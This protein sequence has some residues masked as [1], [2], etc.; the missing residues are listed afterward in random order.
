MEAIVFAGTTEGRAVIASLLSRKIRT[1]ACIA[2]D[3]GKEILEDTIRNNEYLKLNTGRLDM[4]QI[5]TLIG[6][7]NAQ[8]LVIDATHPYAKDVT[9]NIKQAC[10]ETGTEYIR[11]LR[12]STLSADADGKLVFETLEDVISWA[13]KDT[14]LSK[15]LLLTTGSKDLR[16]Y[17]SIK[18]YKE[19]VYPRI[20]PDI[21]SLK[22]ASELGYKKANIICMQG[23]FS[24]KMNQALIE[25]TGV[26]AL[27]TKDT[28]KTGGFDEKLEAAGLMGI[29]TLVIKRPSDEAVGAYELPVMSAAEFEALIEKLEL[30]EN[31]L[32]EADLSQAV[33][34]KTAAS[35]ATIKGKDAETK[36]ADEQ[37]TLF[38]ES[39]GMY[40]RF[41]LF[42][43]LRD[44]K[45]TVIGAGKIAQRRIATLLRYGAEIKV[46]APEQTEKIREL[47]DEGKLI[48]KERNYQG[49]DLRG[50][51]LAVS[52]SDSRGVNHRVYEEAKELSIPVSIADEKDECSFYF[53]AV[54]QKG[55]I[56]IGLVSD[57]SDHS[58]TARTAKELRTYLDIK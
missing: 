51:V 15:K 47:A 36:T 41:P 54:M 10:R 46:I 29:V 34:E 12:K 16:A 24:T 13:N 4:Q 31:D 56:S 25:A 3:Y 17:T 22:N 58:K 32:K 35:T 6:S 39:S 1:T 21:D 33:S 49:G 43:D 37:S 26:E 28:G 48:L 23:P 20:L 53:P 30:D 8:K 52:A 55:N 50:S 27:V 44:K 42:I 19:R 40:P 9:L 38:S 11:I 18:N 2:T 57:G 45:I 5:K 14:N 7:D